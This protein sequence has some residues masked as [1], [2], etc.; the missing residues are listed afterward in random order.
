[1]IA[2]FYKPLFFIV[3]LSVASVTALLDWLEKRGWASR[4]QN[5]KDRRMIHT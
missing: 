2:L 1:M 5:D 3:Q 4:E